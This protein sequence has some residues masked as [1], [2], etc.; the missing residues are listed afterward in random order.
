MTQIKAILTDIEGTTSSIDF[1]KTTL[2]PYAKEKLKTFLAT[3]HTKPHIQAILQE[4]EQELD[5]SAKL[6]DIT[7]LLLHWID[8]DQKKTPLKT[9]QG[10]I[11]EDGYK[12][13]D[14]KAHLYPD[15]SHFLNKWA[16]RIPIYIYSSGSVKA[17]HLFF[18]H[19]KDGN[20]MPI[21][22]GFYDTTTGPKKNA[23]SYEAIASDIRLNPDSILFLSDCKDE[24]KAASHAGFKTCL[25]LR[26][27]LVTQLPNASYA[28][29]YAQ[30]FAQV[31]ELFFVTP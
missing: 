14:F 8:T 27:T 12:N 21:L 6:N 4:V 20:L 9:L 26:E 23:E 16:Q 13:G 17:Q 11:W 28:H 1:V 22:S 15:T 10:Y 5:P 31:D 30:N 25:I 3:E 29:P 24:I 2:F 7:E 19:S 18:T